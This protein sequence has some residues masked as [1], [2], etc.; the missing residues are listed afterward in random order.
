MT[1]DFHGVPGASAQCAGT[2]EGES[3]SRHHHWASTP[4]QAIQPSLFGLPD[5]VERTVHS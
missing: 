2:C 3:K 5:V 4:Y 1:V